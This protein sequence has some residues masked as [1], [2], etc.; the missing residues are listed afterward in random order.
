MPHRERV[1]WLYLFAMIATYVPYFALTAM[2]P[3]SAAMP[4]WNQLTRLWTTA[5]AQVFILGIG[6]SVFRR[7]WPE[8]VREPM[9]ERDRLIDQRSLRVAYFVLIAGVIVVGV[10]MPFRDAGWTIV[11]AALAAIV[12]AELVHYGIVV[13]SYRRGWHA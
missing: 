11:N 4:D 7:V 10:V 3:P 9:D 13:R 8:D 2:D 1:A 5:V 6:Y 12:M